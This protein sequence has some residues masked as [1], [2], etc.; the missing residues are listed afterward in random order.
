M[1]QMDRRALEGSLRSDMQVQ[2]L[3]GIIVVKCR[4]HCPNGYD[5]D[6]IL[7]GYNTM[8]C[9]LIMV[10]LEQMCCVMGC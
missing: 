8:Y 1:F 2:L 7:I 4:I 9:V 3:E 10:V 5:Q 6:L